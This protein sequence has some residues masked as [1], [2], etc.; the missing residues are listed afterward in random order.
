MVYLCQKFDEGC[1]P[2]ALKER[3]RVADG[4]AIKVALF[5]LCTQSGDEESV[6]DGLSLPLET[7]RRA[8]EFWQAAGLISTQPPQP[9]IIQQPSVQQIRPEAERI[10]LSPSRISNML[11]DNPELAALL[12]EAQYLLGRPLDNIES[13][14]LLE[15]FEYEELPVDVILMIVAYSLPRAKNR[16]TAISK[17]AR[18]AASWHEQGVCDTASAECRLRLLEHRE[19]REREVAELLGEDA[20]NFTSAQRGYIARW[21]EEYGYGLEFINE[22]YLRGG[23]KSINYIN[24]MLKNWYRSGYK[25]I[26]DTR[27][28]PSNAPA[29]VGKKGKGGSLLKRA[30]ERRQE[31]AADGIQ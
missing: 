16:R 18:M 6:A 20:A 21:Q 31:V 10:Q 9:E 2:A 8:L 14:I 5:L 7:V 13:R 12:Q 30:I 23:S 24:G 3:Y 11:L 28:A 27:A 26:K 1:L 29:P 22:A 17:A 4:P 15:I 25:T 19:R